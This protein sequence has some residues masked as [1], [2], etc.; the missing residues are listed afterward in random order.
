MKKSIIILTGG[1]SGGH[2]TPILAVAAEIK[3][4]KPDCKLIYIGQTGDP[5]GDIPSKDV[6]IDKTYTVRAGKYRR[7][8]GQGFKQLFDIKTLILNIRDIFYI[9]TGLFQSY[10]LI[11]RLQPAVIFSRGGYVSVPVCIGGKLNN[12]SYI[13]HD[14][15][16]IPSLANRLIARWAKWHAVA[17]PANTYPY[18]KDKTI[19]VGVPINQEYK[20]VSAEQKINFMS[21]IG[22]PKNS[23]LLLVT[24][25]GNGAENLNSSIVNCSHELLIKYPNLHIVHFAGR[26]LFESVKNDYKAVLKP[27]QIERIKVFGY[28]SDHYKYSG[29]ADLIV[30]RGGATSLAE[31]AAQAKPCIVIPSPQ[32]I[33]NVKNAQTLEKMH[34]VI[35]LA[36][37]NLKNGSLLAEK[38]SEVLDSQSLRKALSKNIHSLSKPQAAYDLADLIIKSIN[39]KQ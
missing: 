17:L 8:H 35:L 22:V 39:S 21:E 34:A 38:V 10:L 9:L 11:R 28:A 6:N 33:W 36:E 12:V 26:S 13:T 15:D 3:K 18:P 19:T 24:G 7:Y 27:E 25:G 20:T 32:L 29:A 4:K 37:K 14:S 2:I 31:I 5:L 16:S 30:A 1:G 23:Q